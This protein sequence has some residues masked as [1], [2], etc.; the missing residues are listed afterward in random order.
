MGYHL[1]LIKGLSYT[2]FDGAIN[3][4]AE[5]PGVSVEDKDT[6]DALVASGYFKQ[7]EAVND[8][9][10]M[11]EGHLDRAQL[12]GMKLDELKQL[13]ADL[14]LD[15]KGLTKK[16]EYV[17]AI[18]SVEVSAPAFDAEAL[19]AMAD[20]ELSAFAKERNIDLGNCKTRKDALEAISVALGGSYTVL[21]LLRR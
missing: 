2:G 6:A 15:T 10:E 13:A 9:P 7:V 20:E 4:T 21:D 12:E 17:E 16:A 1:K 3:A 5:Q 18:A 14:G 8:E 19:A 11:L